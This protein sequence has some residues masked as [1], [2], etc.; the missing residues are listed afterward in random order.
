[1][2]RRPGGHVMKAKGSSGYDDRISDGGL[3][4]FGRLLFGGLCK[5]AVSKDQLQPEP[6]GIYFINLQSSNQCNYEGE[7]NGTH[8]TT[9]LCLPGIY[10][11]FDSFGFPPPQ[12]VLDR[13][14][15]RRGVHFQGWAQPFHS[16]LCGYYD[17]YAMNALMNQGAGV[18]MDGEVYTS[19]G[20]LLFGNTHHNE[21]KVRSFANALNR[22]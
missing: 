18:R 4:T 15:G 21:M 14:K 8:W 16:D 20:T 19:K 9:L 1:M 7:C 12:T 17:L 22:I 5:G 6:T 10:F 13:L 2:D 11:Y 3:M